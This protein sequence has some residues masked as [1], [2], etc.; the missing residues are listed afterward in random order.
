MVFHFDPW[1]NPLNSCP[2]LERGTQKPSHIVRMPPFGMPRRI[3][4][5][6]GSE[7][8]SMLSEF[9]PTSG[10][11][12][13]VGGIVGGN[14]P[15]D[16]RRC[17]DGSPGTF[18]CITRWNHG[19]G[20]GLWMIGGDER[21]ERLVRYPICDILQTITPFTQTRESIELWSMMSCI[22]YS[23][24]PCSPPVWCP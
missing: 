8:L 10:W 20:K 12:R 11:I 4:K 6:S 13:C 19:T 14:R 17:A 9:C 23:V 3:E 16:P 24:P 5:T 18:G 21:Y 7:Y 15:F 2:D 1:P 22:K